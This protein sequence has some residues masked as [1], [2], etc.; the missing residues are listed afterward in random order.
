MYIPVCVVRQF[1]FTIPLIKNDSILPVINNKNFKSPEI[2]I[3]KTTPLR[4]FQHTVPPSNIPQ[5]TQTPSPPI[6]GFGNPPSYFRDIFLV[7]GYM[8]TVWY[9]MFFPMGFFPRKLPKIPSSQAAAAAAAAASAAWFHILNVS[10]LDAG[11]AGR[12]QR[13]WLVEPKKTTVLPKCK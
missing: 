2:T 12:S 8:G 11:P 1:Y 4:K 13:S 6:Y 5:T 10:Q 9:G 3:S 7:L